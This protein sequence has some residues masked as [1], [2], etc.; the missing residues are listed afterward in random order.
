MC[1]TCAPGS[2]NRLLFAIETDF[3]I[4]IIIIIILK[5]GS[6][7]GYVDQFVVEDLTGVHEVISISVHSWQIGN[8]L[9]L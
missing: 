9:S 6:M 5:V 4:I 1:V 8:I 2:D 3:W 7:L